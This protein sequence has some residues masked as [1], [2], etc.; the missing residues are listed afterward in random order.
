M[1]LRLYGRYASGQLDQGLEPKR[2][3]VGDDDVHDVTLSVDPAD[4]EQVQILP[5]RVDQLLD[6]SI[7]DLLWAHGPT[8]LLGLGHESGAQLR[9]VGARDLEGFDGD[10]LGVGAVSY[11][12][13]RAHETR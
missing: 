8:G 1:S 5:G 3:V 2:R 6:V 11:T 7:A 9:P 4:R 12:H 10:R 13:L